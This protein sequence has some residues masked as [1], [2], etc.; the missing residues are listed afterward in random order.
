M[1][2]VSTHLCSGV[3][4]EAATTDTTTLLTSTTAPEVCAELGEDFVLTGERGVK[5]Q[6]SLCSLRWLAGDEVV[7]PAVPAGDKYVHAL[8]ISMR[9]RSSVGCLALL[10]WFCREWPAPWQGQS[11]RPAQPIEENALGRLQII[12]YCCPSRVDSLE[13]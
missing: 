2:R 3:T 1:F 9:F 5:W 8:G 10:T 4:S 11:V 7:F 13:G 12:L 6:T